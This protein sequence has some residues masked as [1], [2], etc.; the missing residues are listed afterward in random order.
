MSAYATFSCSLFD[1][2]VNVVAIVA[3]VDDVLEDSV[4]AVGVVK[5]CVAV[6][7]VMDCVVVGVVADN[8]TVDDIVDCVVVTSVVVDCIDVDD[9]VDCMVVDG[10]VAVVPDDKVD[11]A[12]A[13]EATKIKSVHGS[14]NLFFY[15]QLYCT[16]KFYCN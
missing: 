16:K 4:F 7:D 10:S 9:V 5:D 12:I 6:D 15:F 11:D 13:V 14:I 8:V 3:V 2:G 1:E